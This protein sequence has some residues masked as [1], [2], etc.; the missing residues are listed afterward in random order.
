MP[1][2]RDPLDTHC[3]R[4]ELAGYFKADEGQGNTNRIQ[5]VESDKRHPVVNRRTPGEGGG[6]SI[7]TEGKA[8]YALVSPD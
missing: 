8:A 7:G 4:A 5:E 2:F 6:T 1:G 3:L